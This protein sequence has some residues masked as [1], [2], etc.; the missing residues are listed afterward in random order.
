FPNVLRVLP[1]PPRM[2][3]QWAETTAK[4][5]DRADEVAEWSYRFTWSTPR[6][7]QDAPHVSVVFNDLSGEGLA[8]RAGPSDEALFEALASFIE[9]NVRLLTELDAISRRIG[10]KATAVDEDVKALRARLKEFND[11][12]AEVEKT[13]TAWVGATA[14]EPAGLP[15]EALQVDFDIELRE[16]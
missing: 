4:Q 3:A 13:Y 8:S 11:L 12:L 16:G 1:S 14:A 10:P 2:E 9:E 7:A 5:G 15:A 6:V